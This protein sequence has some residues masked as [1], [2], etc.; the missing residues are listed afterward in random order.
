MRAWIATFFLAITCFAN[1]AGIVIAQQT[2]S[3][4]SEVDEQRMLLQYLAEAFDEDG[5]LNPIAW[6]IMDPIFRSA[7]ASKLVKESTN[8][9]LQTVLDGAEKLKADYVL[10][11]TVF[12]KDTQLYG[13]LRLFKKGQEIWK[14][15]SDAANATEGARILT[16]ES[17]N[18]F[19]LSNS[20]RGAASTW[21]QLMFAEPL[22]GLAPR[23]RIET[24]P[25]EP[26]I[27]P[28]IP[29]APPVTKVD[30]RELMT[31]V[32]KLL[33]TGKT[34]EAIAT[35]RDAVD[36]E[37]LDAERRKALANALATA[38]LNETAAGE[39]RRAAE[40]FPD[41]ADLRTQAARFWMAAGKIDEANLDLN[42]AV[43]RNPESVETRMLLGEVA[44][45]KLQ[46]E[47]AIA[48]M[49][50]VLSKAPNA[51]AL[52]KRSLAKAMNDDGEGSKKDLDEAVRLGLG[53]DPL[54]V[55]SQYSTAIR[56]SAAALGEM[57]VAMR[58]LFQRARANFGSKEVRDDRKV[59]AGRCQAL[60][61]LFG[62]VGVPP[63]HKNSQGRLV[64][65]LKLLD[66]A[67]SELGSYLDSGTDDVMGDA[68]ITLG[69]AIKTLATA[70]EAYRTELGH[71]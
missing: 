56:V 39:A 37:P 58:T 1:S 51:D 4:A 13:R 68:T 34:A 17:N 6:T 11:C 33:A 54:E 25:V 2:A 15:P 8:P 22:K 57:T 49:D 45:S 59:L 19:D 12:R 32:M 20:L 24:P 31:Q 60:V 61:A 26:G 53:K 36:A 50:F 52:F 35:L 48:H 7:V 38:G 64:L 5:R 40:L 9:D 46:I 28:N 41:Q 71:G 63:V 21:S 62:V 27:K 29:D 23:Q 16:V 30:N 69:E 3:H 14:D 70:N 66:Q 18:R 42:E 10:V 55:R 65:A 44:L 43:A 67:L 47:A